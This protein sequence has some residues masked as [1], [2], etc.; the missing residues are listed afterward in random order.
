MDSRQTPEP[1]Q[2]IATATVAVVGAGLSG[3]TAARELA[4]AGVDVVVLEAADRLGGRA[5]TETT[6]LGSRV[7]LGGQWIGHDHHRIIELAEELGAE[8]FR[9][10]TRPLPVLISGSR[11]IRPVSPSMVLTAFIVAGVELLSRCRVTQRWNATTVASWLR[12]VPGHTTRRLLEVIGLVS[13]TADLDRFSIHAMASTIRQQGGLKAMLSTS[14]GAQESLLTQGIGA[15]VDGLARDLGPRVRLSHRVTTIARSQSGVT[16][17]TDAGV[18]RAAKVIV[19]V[20]PPSAARITFDPQLPGHRVAL[21]RNTYMGSVYKAIAIYERPFW[22]ERN[23]SEFIILDNPGR[24]VFDTSPPGGP[25]HLCVL[26]A[27]PDA[28]EL[29]AF[30][31]PAR[32]DAILSALSRH[33][34]PEILEPVDWHEKSWHLDENVGGGYVALPCPGTTEGLLPVAS[35]PV[36]DIHW[37]GTETASHHPGYLDGAIES[38]IRVANEVIEALSARRP[39]GNRVAAR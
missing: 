28:R 19:T 13:W 35:T 1:S 8:R 27:G 26:V 12:R 20:P 37:A 24:A 29:D 11:R 23:H 39:A 21:S 38:G 2:S 10:H 18:V 7:D 17:D 36:G 32:R 25:G 3:L 14:G 5:M 22:R 30:D 16:L 34:G 9:M 15:L 31:E 4:R 6:V 33:I